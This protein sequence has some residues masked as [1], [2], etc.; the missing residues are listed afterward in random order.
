MGTALTCLGNESASAGRR[1][2]SRKRSLGGVGLRVPHGE[3]WKRRGLE[4]VEDGGR[5]RVSLEG[6]WYGALLDKELGQ[7]RRVDLGTHGWSPLSAQAMCIVM[8]AFSRSSSV[9][10]LLI[11][12]LVV[13]QLTR[14]SRNSDYPL[15]KRNSINDV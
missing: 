6:A 11:G 2:H 7:F 12:L 5:D 15:S 9:F 14:S 8:I 13:W 4:H 1:A 10:D 3:S